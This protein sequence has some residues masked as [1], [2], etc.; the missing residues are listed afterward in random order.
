MRK[1]DTAVDTLGWL[2]GA[3]LAAGTSSGSARFDTSSANGSEFPRLGGKWLPGGRPNARCG[4][5]A[6]PASHAC[7]ARLHRRFASSVVSL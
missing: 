4:R 2:I 6:S 1:I 7:G 3:Y 5:V